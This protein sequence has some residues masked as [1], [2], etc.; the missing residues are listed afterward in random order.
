M[1]NELLG[2][3]RLSIIDNLRAEIRERE[4]VIADLTREDADP[5]KIDVRTADVHVWNPTAGD[6]YNVR[7]ETRPTPGDAI[8]EVR[9]RGRKAKQSP[10][11]LREP[12]IAFVK[13]HP[14]CK[15]EQ[16]REAIGAKPTQMPVL[17]VL[18]SHAVK[19]KG[20]KRAMT[21]WPKAGAK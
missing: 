13:K 15:A 14:G 4:G 9:K 10:E 8:A 2:T 20:A 19:T 3:L 18:T 11:D 5:R 12:M 16:I 1:R 17:R 21:Y 7:L 6:G